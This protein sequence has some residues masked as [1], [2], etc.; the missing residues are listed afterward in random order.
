[1]LIYILLRLFVPKKNYTLEGDELRYLTTSNNFYKLWMRSFYDTHPPLYAWLIRLF[2]IIGDWKSGILTSLLCS[3]AL[4]IVCDHLYT[5]L[6]LTLAQKKTALMFLTFNYT[7]IYYSNRIFRY[8][9]IA[10]LGTLTIWLMFTHQYF[11]GGLAW[12]LLGITCSYVALRGFW[13]WGCLGFSP[14]ALICFLFIYGSWIEMKIQTYLDHEYYPSGI[15]GKI[16]KTKDFTLRQL[17]SPLYFPWTYAYYGKREL[18]YDFKGWLRKIGGV[19]GFYQTNNRIINFVMYCL[20][21]AAVVFTIRGGLNSPLWLVIL[22][23]ALLYPSL[24]K[25]FLP[26]NS[27]IAIPLLCFM[28]GKGVPQMPAGWV[29]FAIWGSVIGFLAF[30]RA[31]AFT[32][33]H[34]KARLT[35]KYLDK[36]PYGNIMVEGLIAYPIAYRTKRK[37]CV[38]P[39]DPDPRRARHQIKLTMDKFLVKY[40]VFS[41]LYATE[42]HLGYPAIHYLTNTLVFNG[43]CWVKKFNL[44]K[45]IKEDGDVYY[46]YKLS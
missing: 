11:A 14:V 4:Y 15:D 17:I 40:A 34:I 30:M 38:I 12:G 28:L 43:S 2:K 31:T 21:A 1:M 24:L 6:G 45:T 18:G 39:H 44:I 35:S 37:I 3:I 8:Q 13:I 5:D 33:P 46:V 23:L 22:T 16:E 36:L 32:R 41:E 26:R 27:I 20:T 7:L 25:R 42:K 10:L 9:L 29:N 19:F